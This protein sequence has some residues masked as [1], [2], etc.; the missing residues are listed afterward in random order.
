MEQNFDS[1][2]QTFKVPEPSPSLLGRVTKRIE[3]EKKRLVLMRRAVLFSLATIA[4]A[5][6]FAEAARFAGAGLAES[7]FAQFF[8]LIF[9][10]YGTVLAD[11]KDFVLSLLEALPV[12]DLLFV[13]LCVLGLIYSV[14]FLIRDMKILNSFTHLKHSI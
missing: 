2:F 8:S 3:I 9:S 1:L 4:S 7:G 11:W 14:R 12:T 6:A 5:G 13:F 10:D